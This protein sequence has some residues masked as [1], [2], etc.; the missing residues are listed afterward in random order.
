M[1]ILIINAGLSGSQGNCGQVTSILSRFFEKDEVK[2]V[3][4]KNKYRFGNLRK[5]LQ[6]S[7]GVIF[8]TGTY[9]DSWS[10]H[11]QKLL[12]DMTPL[13]CNPHIIGKPCLAVVCMHS[14]GG[15]GV[16]TR[17]QGVLNTFGF[18]IPPLG[19][20]VLSLAA[21]LAGKTRSPHKKDFWSLSDLATAIDNFKK[22]SDLQIQFSSWPVDRKNFKS[23]WISTKT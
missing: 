17:L 16:L 10:H 3:H 12:E 8:I 18:V 13:E 20:I 22:I 21:Q 14:V 6:Q 1:K 11:M 5:L 15:K 23:K 9:W 19:G 2:I 7:E 4:L